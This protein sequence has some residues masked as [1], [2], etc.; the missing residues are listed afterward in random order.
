[1]QAYHNESAPRT[2]RA[3]RIYARLDPGT[4]RTPF[5]T[6]SNIDPRPIGAS[7][8]GD[9]DYVLHLGNRI[10]TLEQ[11]DM[12][13][14]G[15]AISRHEKAKDCD[16]DDFDEIEKPRVYQVDEESNTRIQTLQ[17]L[18]WPEENKEED[19]HNLLFNGTSP[20]RKSCCFK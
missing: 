19:I 18:V 3:L 1:M 9:D 11:M 8:T 13:H 10:S 12:P 7:G 20:N 16:V 6:R 2:L 17:A 15:G 14:L 4:S 5:V